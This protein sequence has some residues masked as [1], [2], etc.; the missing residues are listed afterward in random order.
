MEVPGL[1]SRIR[2]AAMAFATATAV[3][4]QAVFDLCCGLQQCL[5]LNPLSEVRDRTHLFVD[6]IWFLTY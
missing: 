6:T 4:V 3:R 1:R 5:I 2:A